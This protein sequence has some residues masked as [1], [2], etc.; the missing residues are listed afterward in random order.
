M[1]MR[2]RVIDLFVNAYDGNKH[3]QCKYCGVEFQETFTLQTSPS[4]FSCLWLM[5]VAAS[6]ILEFLTLDSMEYMVFINYFNV[7]YMR[8]CTFISSPSHFL[9][10][11]T[12]T[13][14]VK[15]CSD[16][17]QVLLKWRLQKRKAAWNTAAMHAQL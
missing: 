17:K 1:W 15:T 9:G 14:C 7:L 6:G 13:H 4:P 5:F 2:A 8:Y 10:I 11:L 3:Q 16:I 12:L